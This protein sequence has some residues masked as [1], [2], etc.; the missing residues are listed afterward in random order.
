MFPVRYGLNSYFIRRNSVSRRIRDRIKKL[1]LF[2]LNN[3]EETSPYRTGNT[4]R[5]RYKSHP[6]HAVWGNS[7]CLL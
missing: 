6:V 2:S 3:I 1:V 7:R 5:H 4:L